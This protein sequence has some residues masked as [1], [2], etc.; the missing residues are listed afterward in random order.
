MKE[1]EIPK[2][3][4]GKYKLI[5]GDLLFTEGGDW[6]K[7]GRSAVWRDEVVPCIHQNHV[8]RARLVASNLDPLWFS[9]FANS[10]IGRR[11]F[12]DAA[13]QTTNL[14]S[15]NMTQLRHCPMPLPPLGEKQRIVA[16]VEHLMKVC[17]DLEASLRRAEDR[18]SKLV[19]SAVQELVA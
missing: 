12:A 8:F 15:I 5:A 16:K 19:E 2:E 17:D 3:E 1:I 10:P 11:Y 6:D 9:L 14:A 7:L 4:L 18:A 13:K